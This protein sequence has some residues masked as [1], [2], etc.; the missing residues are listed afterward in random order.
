MQTIGRFICVGALSLSLVGVSTVYA[1]ETLIY[2]D[3]E[4]T[5]ADLGAEFLRKGGD[6][7]L[8]NLEAVEAG[9][10]SEFVNSAIG[11]PYYLYTLP[12][13][14]QWDYNINVPFTR[15]D[16]NY[17]VCQ[18]K[19][20]FSPQKVVE[21]THWRRAICEQSY[22]AWLSRQE[23]TKYNPI[24][25]SADVLFVFDTAELST[26][27]VEL[28][29]SA[30]NDIKRD[31]QSPVISLSGHAD[32]IGTDEYNMNL[33]SERADSVRRQFVE[34]GFDD[35]EIN[36]VGRGETSPVVYCDDGLSREALIE[37]LQPNRRVEVDVYE[38][39]DSANGG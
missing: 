1:A 17:L 38:G 29:Q 24:N 31:F 37:C 22:L 30:S 35:A 9:V 6:M 18:Y 13:G 16:E 21:E 15:D 7:D 14:E 26:K 33:S 19:V 11:T 23:P 8:R 5:V 36:A 28:L 3:V 39:A 34:M 10:T 27:G 25:F 20:V 12:K 2:H 32:R 4:G